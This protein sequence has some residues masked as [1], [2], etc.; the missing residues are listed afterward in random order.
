[1]SKELGI[2]HD[3]IILLIGNIAV[4]SRVASDPNRLSFSSEFTVLSVRQR[5][6]RSLS[7]SRFDR[8]QSEESQDRWVTMLRKRRL[9]IV[10]KERMT[11]LVCD[12][13][14]Q[15]KNSQQEGSSSTWRARRAKRTVEQCEIRQWVANCSGRHR[16]CRRESNAD[17]SGAVTRVSSCIWVFSVSQ[18]QGRH[19]RDR[20]RRIYKLRTC[21]TYSSF[22]FIRRSSVHV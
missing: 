19:F 11:K 2:V 16:R 17:A 4:L 9:A 21:I 20:L 7:S 12:R 8:W 5:S 18:G 14:L 22:K 10:R 1:M 3:T 15:T 6:R 13:E